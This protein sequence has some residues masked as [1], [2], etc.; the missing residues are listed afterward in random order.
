MKLI[1]LIF[2][3]SMGNKK[4]QRMIVAKRLQ[5]RETQQVVTLFVVVE[6]QEATPAIINGGVATTINET[7][8]KAR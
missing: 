5:A 6:A 3:K 7:T 4:N 2:G 8:I 1:F